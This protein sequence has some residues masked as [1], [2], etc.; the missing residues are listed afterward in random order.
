[1]AIGKDLDS[2]AD[3]VT[4][5]VV[6]GIIMFKLIMQARMLNLALQAGGPD[7]SAVASNYNYLPAYFA[8]IIP[9]FSA[10]RLAKFNHDT[11]Q[12]DSFIGLPTPANGI[13]ICSLPFVLNI[14]NSLMFMDIISSPLIL[15]GICA[16]MSFLLVAELP[17]LALKFKHF[18]WKGNE[19]RLIFLVWSIVLLASLQFIGVPLVI[20]SYIIFSLINNW[21]LKP[22]MNQ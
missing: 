10:I 16:L 2:L 7:A 13:F 20:F 5:G 17:L 8:F 18:N 4:F 19:L 11:R 15:C 3:M 6:P 14:N 1:S 22:K 12:S 9:I 21:F